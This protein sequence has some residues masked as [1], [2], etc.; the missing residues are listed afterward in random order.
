MLALNF[1]DCSLA[2][3]LPRG[4][5]ADRHCESAMLPDRTQSVCLNALMTDGRLPTA[6]RAP[7]MFVTW[8][9]WALIQ[10]GEWTL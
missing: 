3:G 9:V 10:F 6:C 2:F 5:Q 1:I 7:K 8:A 4:S